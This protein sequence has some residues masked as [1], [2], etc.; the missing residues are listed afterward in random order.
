VVHEFVTK[1][2][3]GLYAAYLVTLNTYMPLAGW[4]NCG[5]AWS[6]TGHLNTFTELWRVEKGPVDASIDTMLN[7]LATVWPKRP[8]PVP[9]SYIELPY[10]L[11]NLP[12]K[13]T[14]LR[15]YAY[16]RT[17]DPTSWVRV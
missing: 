2:Q 3:F 7:A 14:L 17:A 13:R 8:S 16:Q 5:I 15:E 6:T 10:L 9:P 12:Q 1:A 11:R 4:T